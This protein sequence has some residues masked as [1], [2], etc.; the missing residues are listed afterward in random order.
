M[1]RQ[2]ECLGWTS[3][4]CLTWWRLQPES[5]R[6]LR[7]N[8]QPGQHST[9]HSGAPAENASQGPVNSSA[10][11]EQPRHH[12]PRSPQVAGHG[13]VYG[14]AGASWKVAPPTSP[15]VGRHSMVPEDWELERQNHSSS[16][17]SASSGLV[18]ISSSPAR[19]SLTTQE[20]EVTLFTD[21]SN[22]GWEP[23]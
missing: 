17:G 18:G 8:T 10:L 12:S 2:T 22:S 9:V 20:T 3:L 14:N 6:V 1:K 19:S 13:G 16:V 21:A 23:N 15:V 11:D 4:H 7:P 5:R